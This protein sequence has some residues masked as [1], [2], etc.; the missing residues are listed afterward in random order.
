MGDVVTRTRSVSQTARVIIASTKDNERE[1][2]E[3]R[4]REGESRRRHDDDA[5]DG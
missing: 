3:R 5:D 4:R 1:G 2:N